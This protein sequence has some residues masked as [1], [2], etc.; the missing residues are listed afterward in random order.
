VQVTAVICF[1]PLG[2]TVCDDLKPGC[3]SLAPS[4]CN[5]L[6]L[7]RVLSV[8]CLCTPLVLLDISIDFNNKRP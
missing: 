8:H 4:I 3:G 6:D 5:L 7:S 2:D 1:D